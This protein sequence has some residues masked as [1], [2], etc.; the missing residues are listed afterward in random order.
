MDFD[1][2]FI[3]IEHQSGIEFYWL[4]L[5]NVLSR[6]NSD[7]D[8]SKGDKINMNNM[9]KITTFIDNQ[10]IHKKSHLNTHKL[11][12]I[13]ND[14]SFSIIEKPKSNFVYNPNIF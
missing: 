11:L 14:S 13:I 4:N 5:Y 3:N 10:R 7:I 6:V 1:S 9:S 12:E 8:N 2:S